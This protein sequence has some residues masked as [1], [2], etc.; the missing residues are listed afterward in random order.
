[1]KQGF[2]PLWVPNNPVKIVQ[3]YQWKLLQRGKCPGAGREQFVHADT[4]SRFVAGFRVVTN[5][6]KKMALAGILISTEH[7][8]QWIIGPERRRQSPGGLGITGTVKI[9]KPGI[10]PELYAKR[11]L[12]RGHR[13][14]LL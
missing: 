14:L 10:I 9:A 2:F 1:M 11:Q 7:H 3:C 6:L 8:R 13:D 12:G 5:R 4:D